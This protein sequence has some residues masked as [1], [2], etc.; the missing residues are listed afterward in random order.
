MTLPPLTIEQ[1]ARPA[2]LRIAGEIDAVNHHLLGQALNGLPSNG[3]AVHL[4]LSGL[5]FID[6]AGTMQL[7]QFAEGPPARRM[8]LHSP[9]HQLRRIS[10]LL[11]PTLEWEIAQ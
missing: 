2:G 1:L 5:A 4:N 7:A 11:W 3:S 9:P 8:V 6:V 10:E